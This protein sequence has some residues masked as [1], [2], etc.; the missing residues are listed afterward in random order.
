[1]L[2]KMMMGFHRL[3]QIWADG[4][5]AGQFVRTAKPSFRG[6]VE[7]VRRSD[8]TEGVKVSPRRWIVERASGGVKNGRRHGKDHATLTESSEA[9]SLISMINLTLKRLQA[10]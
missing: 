8:D 5:D 6:V 3:K 4:G 2:V 1:V 10:G 7:V 9:M